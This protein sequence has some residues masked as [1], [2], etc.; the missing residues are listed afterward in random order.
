MAWYT[1]YKWFSPFRKTPYVNQI[2]LY[3][4]HLF[5][6]WFDGLTDEQRA[7]YLKNKEANDR[8]KRMESRQLFALCD[9]II[10]NVDI[11]RERGI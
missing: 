8:R 7:I 3:R 4:Q 2:Y 6:E 9:Y 1:L 10:S 11:G 5:D